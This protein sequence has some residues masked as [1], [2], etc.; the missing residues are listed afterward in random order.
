MKNESFDAIVENIK[1]I[2]TYIL[3]CANQHKY[4][5]MKFQIIT[6]IKLYYL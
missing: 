1:L 5:S 3:K 2:F 6:K 4:K